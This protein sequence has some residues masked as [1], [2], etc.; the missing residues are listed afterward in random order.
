MFV[1]LKHSI[2]L[3][4][5]DAQQLRHGEGLDLNEEGRRCSESEFEAALDLDDAADLQFT[6]E[7]DKQSV[8]DSDRPNQDES[9][10]WIRSE[11]TGLRIRR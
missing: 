7:D 1:D 6:L 11:Q 8:L 3:E 2:D 5:A 9:C 10:S 4:L